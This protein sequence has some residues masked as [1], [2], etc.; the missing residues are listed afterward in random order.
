MML[1]TR[2][3][4][5]YIYICPS[6]AFHTIKVCGGGELGI[7]MTLIKRL[8]PQWPTFP[9]IH[10]DGRRREEVGFSAEKH[11]GKTSGFA[12]AFIDVV[13]H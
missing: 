5:I 7:I 9:R 8:I 3:S 6:A 11:R 12:A 2:G 4:F 13:L 10:S 1:E